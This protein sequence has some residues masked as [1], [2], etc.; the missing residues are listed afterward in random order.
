MNGTK[1][2]GFLQ[3]YLQ[4][5]YFY[6]GLKIY[7]E[8]SKIHAIKATSYDDKKADKLVV[9]INTPLVPTP[10]KNCSTRRESDI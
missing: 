6:V 5:I 2:N 4:M 8:T 1:S 9:L 10:F 3:H 7:L